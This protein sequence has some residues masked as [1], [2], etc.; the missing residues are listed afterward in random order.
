MHT[1]GQLPPATEDKTMHVGRLLFLLL[2]FFAADPA[3]ALRCGNKLVSEGDPMAKVL[4][5]CGDPVSVQ[6]RT[7]IK[8]GVPR[9]RIRNRDLNP[10][11]DELLINTRSYVENGLVADVKELR[12]GY[13]E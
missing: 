5:F 10:F 3:L 9:S 13:R 7:I 1:G 12:S 4:N 6:Q 8:Q 2:V 11:D